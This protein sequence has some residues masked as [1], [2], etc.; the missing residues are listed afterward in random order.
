MTAGQLRH[1]AGKLGR[2][3]GEEHAALL[4]AS[5]GETLVAVARH[6]PPLLFSGG[7]SLTFLVAGAVVCARGAAGAA[8]EGRRKTVEKVKSS[9]TGAAAVVLIGEKGGVAAAF[10]AAAGGVHC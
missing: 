8:E 5:C 1:A 10:I 7:L 2:A 9:V 6:L 4:H 3:A